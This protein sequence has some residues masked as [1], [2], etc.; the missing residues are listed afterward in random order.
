MLPEISPPPHEKQPVILT[1]AVRAHY[2]LCW[3]E[4]LERNARAS[5]A[6]P[7]TIMLFCVPEDFAAFLGLKV[8]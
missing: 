4:R 2:R 6:T 3:A 1:R 5:T 8:A 7:P